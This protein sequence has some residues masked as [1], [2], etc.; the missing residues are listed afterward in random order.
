M[1]DRRLGDRLSDA[2]MYIVPAISIVFSVVR[3]SGETIIEL[4][5]MILK[6]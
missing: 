5:W 3:F 1:E 4:K 6:M 2:F